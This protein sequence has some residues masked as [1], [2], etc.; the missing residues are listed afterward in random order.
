MSKLIP[1][2]LI[3][4]ALSGGVGAGILL[5]PAAA[6]CPPED[7]A[8]ADAGHDEA[9]AGHESDTGSSEFAELNRQ[10]VVPLVQGGRVRAL[11]VC[12]IAVEVGQGMTEAVHAVAPKLRDAFLGVLFVHAHSGGFEGDFTSGLAIADLKSRLYEAARPVLGAQLRSVLITEIVRQ[13]L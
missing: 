11:V 1:V 13:D 4:A 7:P 3:L 9:A 10:F 12:S 6:D 8:C 2:I 5:K